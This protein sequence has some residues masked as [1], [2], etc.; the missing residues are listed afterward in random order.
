MLGVKQLNRDAQVDFEVHKAITPYKSIM[1]VSCNF[2]F[3][4]LLPL[5]RCAVSHSPNG[6]S[7]YQSISQNS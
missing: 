1:Q 6:I 4:K 7:A 2:S 3:M 5:R